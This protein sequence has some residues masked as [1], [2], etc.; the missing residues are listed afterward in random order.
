MTIEAQTE[1]KAGLATGQAIFSKVATADT[2]VVLDFEIGG[3]SGDQLH[4]DGCALTVK[5]TCG[6]VGDTDIVVTGTTQDVTVDAGNLRARFRMNPIFVLSGDTLEATVTSDNAQDTDVD[7][8]VTP[9]VVAASIAAGDIADD[10][11]TAASIATGAVTK[12]QAGLSVFD[13]SSDTVDANLTKWLGTAPLGLS[14]QRVQ[15]DVQAIEGLASA[16][17]VLG[18]WLAEGVQ[19]VADSGTTTT[20]VDAVLTQAD[21]YWNGAL[22]IFRTGTNIGRTAIITDFDAATDTL[23]FAP[24]VP[25]A[26]TTEGYVLIPGLGHADIAA[27]RAEMDSNSTQ[28]AAIVEDT[29]ELQTLQAGAR[30]AL[31]VP[32]TVYFVATAANGGNDSND[33]LSWL[34]P[35]LT[36]KTVIEALSAGDACIIG[37][38]EFA[39]GD[40]KITQPADTKV[41]G[42][43]L[44][45]TVLTC[46]KANAAAYT[47]GSNSYSADFSVDHP[48]AVWIGYAVGGIATDT[49]FTNALM[50]RVRM[51]GSDDGFYVL[52]ASQITITMIDCQYETSGDGGGGIL[53]VNCGAGT[54]IDAV[55][56][57]IQYQKSTEAWIHAVYTQSAHV[58]IR[59]WDPHI[60]VKSTHAGEN[61]TIYGVECSAGQVTLFGGSVHA[62]YAASGASLNQS[63]TGIIRVLGTQYDR[64]NTIGTIMEVSDAKEIL[65]DTNELQT[66]WKD[67][68]R[69]DLLIDEL[70]VQGDT[71]EA[72]I[73]AVPT[74]KTGYSLASDGLDSI[75][76]T[77]PT[78]VASNFRE[79]LVQVWRRLFKKATMTSTKLKT[80][81][82]NGTDVLSTQTLS[83]TGGTQ[84]Q[85]DSS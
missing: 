49:P 44:D 8:V 5:V 18:L 9:R 43:G 37:P 10:A 76:T 79:M 39:M 15:V 27:I 54:V 60:H 16:A 74:T 6:P 61:A 65:T 71:N 53:A 62:E 19:T 58:H 38:G 28:L 48:E 70:T 67:D 42:A 83:D 85:G 40:N 55:R 80:Y 56:P 57:R 3:I 51:C 36:P 66:D 24:A 26:V 32:G 45:V 72:A 22:L 7:T 35:K 73:A 1:N 11:I 68:G 29:N 64:T 33:G 34:S 41:V 77:A 25:D 21:G 31:R 17:T 47:P 14:S 78:G 63:G 50:E 75:S 82:D 13:A 4:A 30:V 46:A 69:L 23:T 52:S 81:A 59:L 2:E 84:T 12:I 20:L